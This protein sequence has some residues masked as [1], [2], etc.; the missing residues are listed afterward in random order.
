MAACEIVSVFHDI[1]NELLVILKTEHD[2]IR[3]KAKEIIW[4]G[5][6]V[7]LLSNEQAICIA[8][9]QGRLD[10]LAEGKVCR[11]SQVIEDEIK[12]AVC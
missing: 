4:D 5:R 11:C 6:Y 10:G 12:Q 2:T 1:E 8:Y 3:C 9:R 7:Q